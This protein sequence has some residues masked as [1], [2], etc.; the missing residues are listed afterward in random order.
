M[1][2]VAAS[3][4][5]PPVKQARDPPFRFPRRR[6]GGVVVLDG[7]S[8]RWRRRNGAVVQEGGQGPPQH[9]VDLPHGGPCRDVPPP[10]GE[11]LVQVGRPVPVAGKGRAVSRPLEVDEPPVV[12]RRELV[13]GL[14]QGENLVDQEADRVDLAP[15]VVG[16]PPGDL[17][18]HVPR[19]SHPCRHLE[20]GFFVRW[21]LLWVWPT[22]VV[23]RSLDSPAHGLAAAVVVVGAAAAAGL[24][25][26]V[27]VFTTSAGGDRGG[28]PRGRKGSPRRSFPLAVSC[29]RRCVVEAPR[30]A[31]RRGRGKLGGAVGVVL[32]R[33][34]R[35]RRQERQF[36]DFLRN[37]PGDVEIK[38]FQ[39]ER[40]WRE[41]FGF[42]SARVALVAS[43]VW[44]VVVVSEKSH[45]EV[46]GFEITVQYP[47]L[48]QILD[49]I[50]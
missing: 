3:A 46:V 8:W 22:A 28:Q 26:V 42:A 38:D 11:H 2:V 44:V 39:A 48:V 43:I 25:L 35:Q 12:L 21:R 4:A 13:V 9:P 23:P 20:E 30:A 16:L 17:G 41:V 18:C 14:P 7:R 47:V 34:R 10:P 6:V 24:A 29:G 36:L 5:P 40:C 50:R 32:F 45:T 33:R 31:E 19:R 37:H 15:E 49:G 1:V 27:G